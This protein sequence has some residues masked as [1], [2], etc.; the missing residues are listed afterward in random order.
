MALALRCDKKHW[1]VVCLFRKNLIALDEKMTTSRL[2]T[3]KILTGAAVLA[4][5][6]TI[7]GLSQTASSTPPQTGASSPAAPVNT[8]TATATGQQ[9]LEMQS[10][11]GFWGHVNPMA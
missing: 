2:S 1:I 6:L 7:S 3:T 10:H 11:E 9:P 4:F 8:P 5:A